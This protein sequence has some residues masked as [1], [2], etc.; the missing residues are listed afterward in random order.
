MA[1]QETWTPDMRVCV[2]LWPSVP[3]QVFPCN[4]KPDLT[5][6]QAAIISRL[7]AP[8]TAVFCSGFLRSPFVLMDLSLGLGDSPVRPGWQRT[9]LLSQGD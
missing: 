5:R 6:G 3:G 7:Q 8:Q 4:T 2:E 1:A 9:R